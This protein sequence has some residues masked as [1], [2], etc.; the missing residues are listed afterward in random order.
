MDVSRRGFLRLSVAAAGGTVQDLG[1]T[2]GI[3]VEL[4]DRRALG[5]KRAFVVRTARVALDV[6]DLPVDRVHQGGAAHG[7]VGAEAGGD[8]CVLDSQ[9]LRSRYRWT[10]VHS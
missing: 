10:E 6:D 7:A 8:L 9:F 5:A 1:R 3:D 4:E 2:I